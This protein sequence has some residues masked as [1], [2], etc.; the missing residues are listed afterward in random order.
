M[1]MIGMGTPISQRSSERIDVSPG[2][3]MATPAWRDGSGVPKAW[4]TLPSC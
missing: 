2:V 3:V 4:R 1:M